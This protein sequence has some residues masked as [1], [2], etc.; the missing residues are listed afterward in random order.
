MIDLSDEGATFLKMLL[1][2]FRQGL[3]QQPGSQAKLDVMD[4]FDDLE[5]YLREEHSWISSEHK[6]LRDG[7]VQLE[8]GDEVEVAANGHDE[9]D[10][11]GDFAPTI[12]D[13]TPELAEQLG[14][15]RGS[16][17]PEKNLQSM[18][19]EEEQAANE[20]EEDDQDLES[21]DARY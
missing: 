5:T 14:L 6:I 3:D 13:L 4:E 1:K 11:H 9:E 19:S 7:K 21:M 17:G 15:P 16:T 18:V 2:R 20:Y 8:D 10:E 12:V